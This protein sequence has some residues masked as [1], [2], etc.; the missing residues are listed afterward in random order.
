MILYTIFFSNAVLT[1][2]RFSQGVEAIEG[3]PRVIP[4]TPPPTSVAPNSCGGSHDSDD[5]M[6]MEDVHELTDKIYQKLGR[7]VKRKQPQENT[8]EHRPRASAPGKKNRRELFTSEEV[9]EDIEKDRPLVAGMIPIEIAPP[10]SNSLYPPSKGLAGV[11][12]TSHDLED[13]V[14]YPWKD[15]DHL[16]GRKGL[17]VLPVRGDGFCF[18]YSLHFSLLANH[19]IFRS[20][21]D[22]ISDLMNHILDNSMRLGNFITAETDLIQDALDFFLHRNYKTEAVDVIVQAAAD[23]L[24]YGLCIYE[25]RQDHVF[26]LVIKPSPFNGKVIPLIFH[27]SPMSPMLGHYD[28]IVPR[29]WTLPH[30]DHYRSVMSRQHQTE[31]LKRWQ[32]D[33]APRFVDPALKVVRKGD[34]DYQNLDVP[35]GFHSLNDFLHRSFEEDDLP[36]NQ[37]H[38][39]ALAR[40]EQHRVMFHQ[41]MDEG[42]LSDDSTASAHSFPGNMEMAVSDCEDAEEVTSSRLSQMDKNVL[43]DPDMLAVSLRRGDGIYQSLLPQESRMSNMFK[44]RGQGV[45]P[46]DVQAACKLAMAGEPEKFQ[47]LNVVP[48]VVS[49]VPEDINGYK[50]YIIPDCG[51]TWKYDTGDLRHFRMHTSSRQGLVGIRKTGKCRG[52]YRCVNPDCYYLQQHKQPNRSNFI[53]GAV[54]KKCKSCMFAVRR[55]ECGARKVFEFHSVDKFAIVWHYGYHSC[56]LKPALAQRKKA[57]QQQLEKNPKAHGVSYERYG[58]NVLCHDLKRGDIE[59][60]KKNLQLFKDPSITK[61]CVQEQNQQNMMDNTSWDSLAHFKTGMDT[62]DPLLMMEMHN[63]QL[64]GGESYLFKTSSMA[65]K[66]AIEMDASKC[67]SGSPYCNTAYFDTTFDRIIGFRKT[68]ALWTYHPDLQRTYRLA[69]MDVKRD[70]TEV[71]VQFFNKFN[72]A[73]QTYSG[74]KTVRFNPSFMIS[75]H[76]GANINAVEQVF[77]KDMKEKRYMGCVAHFNIDARQKAR[78]IPDRQERERFLLICDGLVN[79]FDLKGYKKVM[80]DLAEFVN[81]HPMMGSWVKWWVARQCMTFGPFRVP[82]ASRSNLSEAGNASM[83]VRGVPQPAIDVCIFDVVTMCIMNEKLQD[84]ATQRDRVVFGRGPSALQ[85]AFKDK[86]QQKRRAKKVTENILECFNRMRGESN[87]EAPEDASA[88]NSVSTLEEV[89]SVGQ[90]TP[91]KNARHRPPLDTPSHTIQGRVEST[92]PSPRADDFVIEDVDSD[93]TMTPL[94]PRGRGRGRPRGRPATRAAA[95]RGGRGRGHNNPPCI[96]LGGDLGG[97]RGRP[98]EQKSKRLPSARKTKTPATTRQRKSPAQRR[99]LEAQQPGTVLPTFAVL[100]AAE[101]ERQIK[102]A[103]DILKTSVP[104]LNTPSWLSDLRNPNPPMLMMMHD[105]SRAVSK[106]H[107][108]EHFLDIST[109]HPDNMLLRMN[110]VRK[111]YHDGQEKGK[112]SLCYFHCDWRCIIKCKPLLEP[113]EISSSSRT[114]GM[115]SPEQM[116]LLAERELLMPLVARWKYH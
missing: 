78:L 43:P 31:R 72:E 14:H 113:T 96:P 97:G 115:L 112:E 42:N 101:T 47:Q 106:C 44:Y 18:L 13:E 70:T 22:L 103:E 62:I 83:C 79:K 6:T 9:I 39:A 4:E 15:V 80:E 100:T 36:P 20:L 95:S 19:N 45:L 77:G 85:V 74:D 68:I 32:R 3:E 30:K 110:A 51:V 23:C 37:E 98:R 10:G 26:T 88:D 56:L 71:M 33:R 60:F 99:G 61:R 82:D 116:V 35:E 57:I 49:Q 1:F 89:A 69:T 55:T 63:G 84:Y 29:G 90:F 38:A 111:Y 109:P 92:L 108:C 58:T 41:E 73:L 11:T 104:R 40:D 67:V 54:V 34:E 86:Q 27:R 24:G 91:H 52:H 8:L 7:S 66:V 46:I 65:A 59:Q 12:F 25:E 16:L 81:C 28:A 2:S 114:F 87:E 93:D 102:I 21:D 105:V 64:G 76:A 75:D 107:G 50:I 17:T 94:R 48:E 53:H 5:G